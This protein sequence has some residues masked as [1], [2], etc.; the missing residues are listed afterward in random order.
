MKS[1][2]IILGVMAAQTSE[3][4]SI[5]YKAIPTCSYWNY[6]SSGYVC[7]GYP[8]TEYFPD[9]SSLD[10]KIRSLEEKIAKLEAQ[11]QNLQ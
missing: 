2:L 8:T 10:M 7:S 4:Q 1:L 11:I 9:R 6:T 3:A 5:Y